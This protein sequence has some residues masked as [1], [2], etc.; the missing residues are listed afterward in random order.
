M[1]RNPARIHAFRF[2]GVQTHANAS[3]VESNLP[4]ESSFSDHLDHWLA[5]LLDTQLNKILG[6]SVHPIPILC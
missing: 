5:W 1:A 4:D 2:D 6:L 3:R